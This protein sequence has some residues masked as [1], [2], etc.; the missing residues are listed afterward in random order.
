[1]TATGQPVHPGDQRRR[2]TYQGEWRTDKGERRTYKG[3]R[4]T[5]KGEKIAGLTRRL[6]R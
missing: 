2:R 5:D 6:A 1:V 4:R 3:E